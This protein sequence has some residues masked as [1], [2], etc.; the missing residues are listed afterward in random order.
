MGTNQINMLIKTKT[1]N[2]IS[3]FAG[4][5]LL[6]APVFAQNVQLDKAPETV[7]TCLQ[8]RPANGLSIVNPP[9]V[10][11]DKDETTGFPGNI[12]APVL[13]YIGEDEDQ[14]GT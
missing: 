13:L 1:M 2:R 14:S 7:T 3:A 8:G 12:E 10:G 4:A 9:L 6:A 5:A 11:I